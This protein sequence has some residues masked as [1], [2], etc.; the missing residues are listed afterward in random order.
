[1]YASKT[2][3]LFNRNTQGNENMTE[4]AIMEPICITHENKR[5]QLKNQLDTTI[6]EVVD[7]SLASFGDSVR[8]VVYF[9]LQNIYH[10]P[11]QEIPTR[12]EEF[13]AA[14]EGIFGIGARLIEMKII[15]TL[16]AKAE[17]FLY[18]PKDEDLVFKDYMQS[19]RCFLVN[20]VTN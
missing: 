2:Q 8:Q 19:F 14:I 10:V 17:G 1:M 6:L 15:E 3:L 9:Q 16:Y 11:K 18:V 13:A 12:I 7:E 20:S 4:T 5:K